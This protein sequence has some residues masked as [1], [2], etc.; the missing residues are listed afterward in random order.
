MYT[1]FTEGDVVLEYTS[2]TSVVSG[3]LISEITTD[4]KNTK[5]EYMSYTH[6]NIL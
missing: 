5:S 4:L 3:V 1:N 2:G 6:R